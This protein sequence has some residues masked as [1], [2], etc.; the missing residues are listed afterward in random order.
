MDL[1]PFPLI[2]PVPVHPTDAFAHVLEHIIGL[3]T[4]TKG[5]RDLV[6]GGVTTVDDLL[7]V[8]M[9]SLRDCLTDATSVMAKTRLKTP[10]CGQKNSLTSTNKSTSK[11][12]LK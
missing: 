9:D 1:P 6:R 3:D 10:K 7:L 11:N 12:S 5:D 4:Q 2:P 8:D